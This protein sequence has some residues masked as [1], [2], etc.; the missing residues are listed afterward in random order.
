MEEKRILQA[1]RE[2]GVL[3]ERVDIREIAFE[4]N[5]DGDGRTGS[6]SR[7]PAGGVRFDVVL[8]RCLSHTRGMY[9]ARMLESQGVRTVN[10]HRAIATCGDKVLTTMALA[11]HGVPTPK[12]AVVFSRD[13]AL[14]VMEK[15]DYPV[16]VKPR[17]GS[18]GR[19]MAKVND[20]EA[21]EAVLEHKSALGQGDT[22][23]IQTYIDKPGRDIR[24]L[25][26]GDETVYAVYRYASHWITNTARGGKTALCPVTPEIDHISRAAALAVGGEIVSVDLL[27]APDGSLWV[28]EVNH[29]PEFHGAVQA[30]DADVA[31]RIVDYVQ[32]VAE[33]EVAR[34]I[35]KQATEQT[36]E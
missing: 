11:Q 25:V 5:R 19:L 18:W 4:L 3:H 31:G 22:Y 13:M 34:R 8:I 7:S 12:T 36:W 6:L 27:E 29:T 2:R 1:L 16:I 28:N 20:R 9:A 17:V 14:T 30:T 33:G 21:A 32:S 24:T 23:Y 35:P 10:L 15:M 26:V